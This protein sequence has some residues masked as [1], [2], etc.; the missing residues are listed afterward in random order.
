[1]ANTAEAEV[2]TVQQQMTSPTREPKTLD[3]QIQ[4]EWT[5][6]SSLKN[7]DSVVSCYALYTAGAGDATSWTEIQGYLEPY[8]ATSLTLTEGVVLF[9]T[10]NYKIKVKNK[11][12]WSA[13]SASV[14]VLSAKKSNTINACKY[15]Y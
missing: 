7:G 15:S 6:V 11:C 13:I 14:G 10:F 5:P 2:D 12:G 4:A 8:S 9:R 3:N 1:M